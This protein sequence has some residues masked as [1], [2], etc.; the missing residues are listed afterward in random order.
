[1]ILS[2]LIFQIQNNPTGSI[3]PYYDLIHEIYNND[4]N[5][6]SFEIKRLNFQL[7]NLLDYS[8]N[9]QN[10]FEYEKFSIF[11]FI[12]QN[13]LINISYTDISQY[14]LVKICYVILNFIIENK[15]KCLNI[16]NV[17]IDES[18][19]DYDFYHYKLKKI[20]NYK[21]IFLKCLTWNC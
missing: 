11:T 12:I 2:I 16:E 8:N 4:N 10:I 5:I 7:I 14:K 18:L 17:L 13:I 15:I 1:M 21:F 6:L 20:N 3:D 19:Y 9:Y